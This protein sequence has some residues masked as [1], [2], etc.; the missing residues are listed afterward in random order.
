[1]TFFKFL[2]DYRNNLISSTI[3]NVFCTISLHSM[4]LSTNTPTQCRQFNQGIHTCILNIGIWIFEF[5]NDCDDDILVVQCLVRKICCAFSMHTITPQRILLP[6]S[7]K[8]LT[9]SRVFC[10][11]LQLSSLS[12][13]TMACCTLVSSIVRIV[14]MSPVG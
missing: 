12:F 9:A 14:R 10:R 6:R 4:T 3:W 2:D 11:T 5:V 8:S 13:L 1:M 7:A